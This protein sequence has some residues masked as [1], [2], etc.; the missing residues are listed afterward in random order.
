[1]DESQLKPYFELQNV[2]E[3]LFHVANKLFGVT[4]EAL[5]DVP[6][7]NPAVQP[8][9][10]HGSEGEFLGVYMVDYYARD[11]KR[12]GAWMSTYRNTSNI[13]GK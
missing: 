10:V 12:G 13:Q 7:W 11:S 1:M 9:T 6:L 2:R 3:G 4:F 5:E 8:Y